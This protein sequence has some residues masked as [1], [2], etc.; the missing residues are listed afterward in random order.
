MG[1][2]NSEALTVDRVKLA[3]DPRFDELVAIY[4]EALPRSERKPAAKLAKMIAQPGYIFLVLMLDGEVV[5]FAIAVCFERT[6]ACLIEYMAIAGQM[7]GQGLGNALF[8]SVVELPEIR[9]RYL[10]AE[11]ESEEAPSADHLDRVRRKRF[12]RKL[13][14]RQIEGLDYIM[15]A[16]SS[17]TPP[18]MNILVYRRE[19]PEDL[20]KEQLRTWLEDIYVNVYWRSSGDLQIDKMLE[21]LPERPRLI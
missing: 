15:P 16:V 13:G 10:L 19:L 8:K 20:S 5:G 21:N 18:A 6:E 14:C 17:S 11:V 1:M 9:D 7:R 2:L 4:R 3:S 12:Y